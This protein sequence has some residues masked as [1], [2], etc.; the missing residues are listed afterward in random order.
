MQKVCAGATHAGVPEQK[1]S[2]E[3]WERCQRCAEEW[4]LHGKEMEA[5][6]VRGD[7]GGNT[8]VSKAQTGS[9]QH[10]PSSAPYLPQVSPQ[11]A[12]GSRVRGPGD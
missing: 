7:A 10:L 8:D 9:R 5:T 4:G 1:H 2:E 12:S 6:W 3:V 11:E